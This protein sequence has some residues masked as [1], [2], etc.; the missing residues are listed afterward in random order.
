MRDGV[1]PQSMAAMQA[2]EKE[3]CNQNATAAAE[4]ESQLLLDH[5]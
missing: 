1:D 5:S 3:V 2:L 4:C